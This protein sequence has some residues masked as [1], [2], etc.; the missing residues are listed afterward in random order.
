MTGSNTSEIGVDLDRLTQ[1][2]QLWMQFVNHVRKQILQ[3]PTYSRIIKDH[4]TAG[5]HHFRFKL[6][7]KITYWQSFF[8]RFKLHDDHTRLLMD[9]L[10][11]HAGAKNVDVLFDKKDRIQLSVKLF[12]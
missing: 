5:G 1:S 9:I 3:L 10:R 6:K 12:G 2:D 8:L 11:H 7:Y 4:D